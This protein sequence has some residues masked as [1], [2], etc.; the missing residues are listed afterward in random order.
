M[1]EPL[2]PIPT[3]TSLLWRQL[4]LQYLPVVIFVA[5]VAAAAFIWTKWV[6]PP[7]LV[8]EVEAVRSEVR[9]AQAGTLV[10]FTVDYLQT[11]KAGQS[12][13]EV[14]VTPP[15]VLEASLALIRAEIEMMR[16][17]LDPVLAQQRAALDFE[18]L[19]LDWMSKRVEL[20]SLQGQLAQA[21][22]SL[23]RTT[24]LH[25]AKLV[26][27]DDFDLAKSTRDSL[28]E[29]V[30]AQ[31][32]L[33]TKIEP[34]LRSLATMGNGSTPST[35]SGLRAAIF[36]KEQELKLVESQLSPL[37]M[38]APIDGVVTMVYRR[39]GET[40]AA[41]EPIVQISSTSTSRIIGFLRQPVAEPPKPGTEVEIRTRTWQRQIA[42]ARITQVGQQ[43]EPISPTILAAMRLPVSTVPTEYGL[44]VLVT[45]PAG[46]ELRP[47]E[48]VDLILHNQ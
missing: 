29:Q 14:V 15:R 35:E 25:Q 5:G 34:R 10:G 28:K 22:S 31:T 48:H 42:T 26:T 45:S 1:S 19:Q 20:A 18:R 30:K 27:D 43:F 24:A 21:E 2:A 8:G 33:I 37:P 47:G 32:E 17:T 7:T 13:G 12:L 9:S 44:R 3:P 11:V 38:I 41:G 39:R 36:H 4:R 40:V 23:A 16:N 46:L 6:A